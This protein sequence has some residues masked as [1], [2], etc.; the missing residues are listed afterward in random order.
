MKNVVG[1]PD[2]EAIRKEAAAWIARLDGDAPLSPEERGALRRW[3]GRGSAHRQALRDAAELWGGLD[4]LAELAP[5]RAEN[6][7]T[8]HAPSRAADARKSK[9]PL[10]AAAAATAAILI[11]GAVYLRPDPLLDSNG[12]YATAVGDQKTLALADGS[13]VELNT[14]TQIKVEYSNKLRNITLLQGEAHFMVAGIEDAP[15]RV[16]A[17][18]GQVIAIG[19]AFAVYLKD[20]T[21]DVTVTK[22]RVS[23]STV[24]RQAAAGQGRGIT[25]SFTDP[26]TLDAGQAA[27]IVN[28]V[29]DAVAGQGGSGMIVELRR[30]ADRELSRRMLWKEGVLAF[31]RA[32][33]GD[34]VAEVRRYTTL[35]IQFADPAVAEIPVIARFPIGDT[36]M[37]LDVFEN[38]FGL[39][40]TYSGPNRVLLAAR[41]GV[42]TE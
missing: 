29:E 37:M 16:D 41:E 17:G 14:N 3:I 35:D 18:P 36:E 32:P 33:L 34:V 2:A 30:L 28:D 42:A 20:E 19:T 9:R 15:F 6:T 39:V 13:V 40:V 38:N 1:F 21:V 5:E 7:N 11:A 27:T 26:V 24:S 12:Y 8:G 10:F 31:S 4:V 23:V 22:G 25:T